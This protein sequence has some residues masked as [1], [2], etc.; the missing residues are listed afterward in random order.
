MSI[1]KIKYI[2]IFIFFIIIFFSYCYFENKI[3][4]ITKIE[5]ED[6]KIPEN[7][8]NFKILHISDLHNTQFGENQEYLIK[9]IKETNPNIIVITGDIVDFNK[10]N[11]NIS[12]EFVKK[13]S[14]ICEIYYVPGN[15]EAALKDNYE[16][17]W[18]QLSASGAKVLNN[19]KVE[20]VVDDDKINLIGL[21][22]IGFIKYKG[23]YQERKFNEIL[24]GL[25]DN[26]GKYN[27]LLSHRPNLMN[28]YEQNNINLVFS[29]H[30]HGGQIRIPFVG[31]LYAPDQGIF[32]KYTSGLY[33][34]N[35]MNLVIS[36]GLG[37]SRFP[38]RINNNPN[39]VVVTLKNI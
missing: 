35:N 32:P 38:W 7:F 9:K 5:I 21:K 33:K 29:G 12:L 28:I 30:A 31:G 15:H 22:D 36:R 4:E 25:V 20:L 13:A 3:I 39:I 1:K 6:S 17:I 27:I 24:S 11:L 18:K 14:K 23:E 26:T 19:E 16:Y 10:P 37:N 8:N 2:S 34:I